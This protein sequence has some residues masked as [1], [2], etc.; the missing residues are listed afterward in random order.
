MNA[1][2]W[3]ALLF[4]GTGI[5]Q[6]LTV[7]STLD[8][9]ARTGEHP[10]VFGNVRSLAGPFDALGVDA[11]IALGWAFVAL[12]AVEIVTGLLLWQSRKVGGILAAVATVLG[13][14]FWL[15]FALPAWLIVGPL[16]AAL[17]ARAWKSLR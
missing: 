12:G 9:I 15:G 16:R 10:L 13:V 5:V 1:A 11:V 2:R 7:P 3:A 17:V 8:H 14:P 6:V 4:L